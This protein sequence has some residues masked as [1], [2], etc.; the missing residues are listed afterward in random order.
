MHPKSKYGSGSKT[1]DF[2]T[3]SHGQVKDLGSCASFAGKNQ[4]VR[5]SRLDGGGHDQFRGK[6]GRKGK[7]AKSTM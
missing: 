5:E 2:A 3:A 6:R 1:G 4:N 7:T